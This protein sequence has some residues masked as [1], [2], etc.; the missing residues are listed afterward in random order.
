MYCP[1]CGTH[2]MENAQ[3]CRSCGA[4]VSLV[5]QALTG[6]LPP[7]HHANFD[8]LAPGAASNFDAAGGRKNNAP[9]F[10][11]AVRN[12]F[13]GLAFLTIALCSAFFMPGG[14]FWWFWMLIPSFATLGGGVA[15]YLRFK[16]AGGTPP[17]LRGASPH[18]E[19]PAPTQPRA[20]LHEPL[21][22]AGAFV[23]PRDTAEMVTPPP[24][25]TEGTTRHLNE[26]SRAK[27]FGADADVPRAGAHEP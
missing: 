15:E 4:N 13:V 7:A 25:V 2:N 26:T 12:I 24:S 1:K 18:I 21:P 6:N 14:R 10:D 27:R 19:M 22:R 11:G 16:H 3:F 5:P 9:S 17:Q 23:P 20:G 8:P